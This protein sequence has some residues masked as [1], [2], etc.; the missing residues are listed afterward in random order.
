MVGICT[1]NMGAQREWCR[2]LGKK[3]CLVLKCRITH[4]L[5]F[6]T[7]VLIYFL[8]SGMNSESSHVSGI[9]GICVCVPVFN[10]HF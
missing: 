4:P 7:L 10:L 6:A 5:E 1:I 8:H 2:Q 9:S 3:I